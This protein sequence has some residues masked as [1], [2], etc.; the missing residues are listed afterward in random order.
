[1]AHSLESLPPLDTLRAFEAAARAGSFSAAA[2]A[3]NLTHGAI[4]RRIARLEGWLGLR[5]FERRAR[6]I[7]LTP[8][9]Q[10]L[11]Q[12]TQ[13]AF[14]LIADTSDRW[15]EPRGP[16]VVRLNSMPSV[17][18]L[19]LMPRVARFEA[20]DP[21]LRII[22]LVEQRTVD[23]ADQAV[24]L[25]IRCGR[26]GL[27]G[28]VSVKLFEE[29]CY[30]IAAPD[31]AKRLGHGDPERLLSAPLIHDSDASGWRAWFAAHGLDYRP[32]QQDRRF[33][34][35]NLVL[36]AAACGLGIA[37]ARPPL[38]HAPVQSGRLVPVDDR[39][40]LNPVSYWL[41]RPNGAIRPA[42]ATLAQRIAEEAG[43]AADALATFLRS[44][45]K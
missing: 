15:S 44:D 16:A 26:G 25:A 41:D 24:D 34:D 33:E 22:L 3:L 40:V 9:G 36:D 28:R 14:A 19:W 21:P 31:L 20:G 5:V 30:P 27:P 38:A 42:A 2:T 43:L 4:S 45:R 8:E 32:R 35:Y 6:G 7:S 37:L 23:L 13:E 1:M 39:T 10:R 12:R 11:F 29:W 17:C 18:S